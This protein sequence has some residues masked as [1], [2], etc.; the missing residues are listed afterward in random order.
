MAHALTKTRPGNDLHMGALLR[1]ALA[2]QGISVRVDK[3]WR[4]LPSEYLIAEREGY[5]RVWIHAASCNG[6]SHYDIPRAALMAVAAVI[7][8][9]VSTRFV[10]NGF[11]DE[12]PRPVAQAQAMAEAV[13]RHFGMPVREVPD[14]F[15]D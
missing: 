11:D 15:G 1:E 5:T 3:P 13:A 2:F 6:D 8:D 7:T 12:S 10:Y 9:D 4:S 14:P